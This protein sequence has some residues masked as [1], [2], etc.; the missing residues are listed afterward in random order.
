MHHQTRADM[1]QD[2]SRSALATSKC[3]LF[4]YA[5]GKKAHGSDLALLGNANGKK[6]LRSVKKVKKMG[7]V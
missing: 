2:Q 6:V 4:Q 3:Y 1:V 7:I 5:E